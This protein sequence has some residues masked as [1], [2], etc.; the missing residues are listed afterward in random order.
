[1]REHPHEVDAAT[2]HYPGLEAVRPQILQQLPH[3][4]VAQLVITAAKAGVLA[5]VQPVTH[6]LCIV[7]RAHA[8]VG[9]RDKLAQTRFAR[10]DQ[11]GQIVGQDQLDEGIAFPLGVLGG[12][13]LD[14]IE[15]KLQLERQGSLRPEGSVVVEDH[16]ALVERNKGLGAFRGGA[17]DPGLDCL[18]G[19]RVLPGSKG[20]G[21][22]LFAGAHTCAHEQGDKQ[23]VEFH[24]FLLV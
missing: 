18:L 15:G 24:L 11:P 17:L 3:G 6:P 10:L 1:M 9:Q 16:I 21:R 5:R 4:Q 13:S 19:R 12:E 20:V 8:A 7:V 14:L 22:T 23:R 2:G